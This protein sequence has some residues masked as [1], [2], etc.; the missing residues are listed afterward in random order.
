MIRMLRVDLSQWKLLAWI[1]IPPSIL[2]LVSSMIAGRLP[3]TL[4]FGSQMA[5]LFLSA[6][7]WISPRLLSRLLFTVLLLA[8][9][10]GTTA[11]IVSG[12]VWQHSEKTTSL[13]LLSA[14]IVDTVEQS[15]IRRWEI[16]EGAK[17]FE[18]TFEARATD[19][20]SRSSWIISQPTINVQ[21]REENGTRF[22]RISNPT[23]GDPYI[24]RYFDLG[25]PVGGRRF[26]VLLEM[27]ASEDVAESACRGIWLQVWHRGGGAR[28]QS[29]ALGPE[30]R[31]YSNTWQAPEEAKSQI[32]R[33]VLNDFDG[34]TYDV[35]NV[36]LFIACGAEWCR[37][38]PLV[39]EAPYVRINGSAAEPA[40][41]ASFLVGTTWR[42]VKVSFPRSRLDDD[43][44]FVTAEVVAASGT[45]VQ[46]R[47]VDLVADEVSLTPVR[48]NTR[49][50]FF[51]PHPNLAGHSL[52]VMGLV[53]LPLGVSAV[54]KLTIASVTL[55]AVFLTGSRAAWLAVILG[56]TALLWL[57][58][59]RRVWIFL[60]LALL[61][62]SA[63][64]MS[65]DNF[66]RLSILAFDNSDHGHRLQI[67]AAY[68]RLFSENLLTGIG[69]SSSA[70][71]SGWKDLGI[72]LLPEPPG[73]AHNVWLQFAAGYGSFGLA[74]IVW[75][76]AGLTWLAQRRG[77]KRGLVII[78][79]VF[80][81]NVFDFTL[82]YSGVYIPLLVGLNSLGAVAQERWPGR[83]PSRVSRET[84]RKAS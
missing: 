1:F 30:W 35:R 25:K 37:L 11:W 12:S 62:A 38:A 81:M 7:V 27:R 2:T 77:G 4:S 50:S 72:T 66:G 79:A 9:G 6:C 82:F 57:T 29:V 56:I 14:G 47:N 52:G 60:V 31:T 32:I 20:T 83:P 65:E 17:E 5:V 59:R 78:A 19:V 3:D 45:D 63:L 40:A 48:N 33:V 44:S 22:S 61:A 43:A 84:L 74:A 76:T 58:F 36:K 46:T 53:L 39:P 13:E 54:G 67:W 70:F 10:L 28:C 21:Q 55:L 64:L 69:G 26:K 49:Q 16:P 8:T 42:E 71:A 80:I 24:M 41:T 73:H 51:F 18:L 15:G 34:V 75:L 68:A 23:G